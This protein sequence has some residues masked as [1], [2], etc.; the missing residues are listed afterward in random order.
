[1]LRTHWI[2][3]AMEIIRASLR[4]YGEE[5]RAAHT[6]ENTVMIRKEL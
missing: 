2:W 6:R 4:F 1:M 5:G 3:G